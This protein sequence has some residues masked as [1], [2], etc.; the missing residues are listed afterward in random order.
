MKHRNECIALMIL[1]LASGWAA[2]CGRNAPQKLQGTSIKTQETPQNQPSN[3]SDGRNEEPCRIVLAELGG[4]TALDKKI[5]QAQQRARAATGSSNALEQ[6]G[7]LFVSKARSSFDPGFYKL[8]EEC[9]VCMEARSGRSPEALLLQGHAL[10]NLHRFKEAEPVAVELVARRGLP[11]DF[12]LLGDVLMEQG[13]LDAAVTAY[14]RMMDLRP[15]LHS[16][17]RG[18]H[19]RWLKGDVE[20]AA[21]LMRLAASAAT[22]RDP[23][24]A[25]W[26][27]TRLAAYEFQRGL[28]L[29]AERSCA[30]ALEYQTNYPPALL[31]RGRML[32]AGGEAEGAAKVLALAAELNPL[33]E[34]QWLLSE[35]LH[36]AGRSNEAAAVEGR[37]RK[38]GAATD[39]R[40]F[41]LFLATR[42]ETP[43]NAVRLG[44]AELNNRQDVFTHDALAWSLAAAGEWGEAGGQIQQALAEG[45]QDA[46]L[47]LHA[48]VIFERMG[49]SE[50][51]GRNFTLAKGLERLLL[52]SE[53]QRL[54]VEMARLSAR[55]GTSPSPRRIQEGSLNETSVLSW[56]SQSTG[57]P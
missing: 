47:F 41:A 46:R 40:T 45:T 18:A 5:A 28:V 29:D 42:R 36:A 54:N 16:Y 15:D 31:L 32:L 39:P 30:A 49:R 57:K 7:W 53:N 56:N 25:A 21:E 9:A 14:Q 13:R 10:H 4:T 27:Y 50:E 8:A 17:S 52:P 48:G 20:G 51:A 2:G 43:E 3:R 35:A 33:P 22:P 55:T 34:Y 26:V 44:R 11:F 19:L 23:E 38:H 12:G 1:T 24:S 6:L 37:L